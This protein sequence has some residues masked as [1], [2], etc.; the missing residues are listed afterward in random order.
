[1]NRRHEDFKSSLVTTDEA[2]KKM[3]PS[4]GWGGSLAVFHSIRTG[5][6][7]VDTSAPT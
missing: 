2:K 3:S 1:L 4:F 5:N 7:V 6:Q